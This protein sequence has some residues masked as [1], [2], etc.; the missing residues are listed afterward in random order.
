MNLLGIDVGT[1]G[2]K[3]ALFSLD[4]KM[5]GTAYREYD[6]QNLQ[7]G[8]AELD[9]AAVWGDLKAAIHTMMAACPGANV[10]A[11]SISSLGEALVPVS[12]DRQILGP[13][14]LNFDSRGEEFLEDLAALLPDE[15][16][17]AINGNTI[18][19]HY[20]LTKL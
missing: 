8:W 4:G 6:A 3:V 15:D 11:L 9:A 17:Y 12:K 13:S 1:T 18:G 7:P 19:N 14:I 10:R 5:L 16:L 2:C 20:S